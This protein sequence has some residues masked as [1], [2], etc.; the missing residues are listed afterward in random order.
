VPRQA[1]VAYPRLLRTLAYLFRHS[2]GPLAE[3]HP[4]SCV[5][6]VPA[7]QVRVR[8]ADARS[9][10]PDDGVLGVQDLRHGL[11]V[12]ADPQRPRQVVASTD[13]VTYFFGFYALFLAAPTGIVRSAFG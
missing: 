2:G 8:S 10:D 3:G 11:V 5:R 1:E 9:R 6:H 7:V 13:R 4:R 12:D